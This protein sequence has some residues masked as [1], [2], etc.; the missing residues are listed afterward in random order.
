MLRDGVAHD[1]RRPLG[2]GQQQARGREGGKAEAGGWFEAA[3]MEREPELQQIRR[4]GVVGGDGVH[5]SLE[6]CKRA[7][8]YLCSRLTKEEEVVLGTESLP[9]KRQRRCV[10]GDDAEDREKHALHRINLKIK[11]IGVSNICFKCVKIKLKNKNA[12]LK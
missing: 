10:D 2:A 4:T 8:A 3:G 12:G 9:E 6:Y 1:Q 5:L 7:A 11:S